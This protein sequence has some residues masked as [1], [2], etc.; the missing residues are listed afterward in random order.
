MREALVST[1]RIPESAELESGLAGLVGSRLGGVPRIVRRERNWYE[2]TFPSELIRIAGPA[3]SMTLLCKHGFEY[4][5][6]VLGHRRG[7]PYEAEVYSVA[8][9]SAGALRSEFVGAFDTGSTTT[10]VVRFLHGAVPLQETQEGS[11]SAVVRAAEVLGALHAM[12]PSGAPSLNRFDGEFFSRWASWVDDASDVRS[13]RCFHSLRPL[14]VE[15][16]VQHLGQA[17]PAVVHGELYAGNVLDWRGE[18]RIIDWE[19]AGVGAGEIDLATLTA[20]RWSASTRRAC[21]A[22]YARARWGVAPPPVFEVRCAAAQLY[23][24]WNL[25]RQ[26][27]PATKDEPWWNGQVEECLQTLAGGG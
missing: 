21:M 26:A 6:P 17:D 2:S 13:M 9:D 18:L 23:A 16:A 20:G 5:H 11:G 25:A 10:L 7:V 1:I 4:L 14:H 19:S 12:A 15:R 22:A 24:L 3:A 8:V 27:K